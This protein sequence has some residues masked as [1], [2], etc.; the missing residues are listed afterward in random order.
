MVHFSLKNLTSGGIEFTIFS[1]KS[2]DH[3]VSRV[4]LNL[5]AYPRF[6]GGVCPRRGSA[7]GCAHLPAH[8]VSAQLTRGG[9]FI[10]GQFTGNKVGG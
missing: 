4:R 6:G 7:T 3:S 5:G 1:Q 2:I 8:G 10:A 9:V